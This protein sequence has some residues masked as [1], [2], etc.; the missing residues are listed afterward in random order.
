MTGALGNISIAQLQQIDGRL[1]VAG[2]DNDTNQGVVLGNGNGLAGGIGGD[3]LIVD[4]DVLRAAFYLDGGGVHGQNQLIDLLAFLGGKGVGDAVAGEGDG[5]G[6][7]G[8]AHGSTGG[9]GSVDLGNLGGL[10][11][12]GTGHDVGGG[13]DLHIVEGLA[14]NIHRVAVTVDGPGQ[15][16]AGACV[17]VVVVVA[18]GVVGAVLHNVNV[19]ELGTAGV[20]AEIIRADHTP[21]TGNQDAR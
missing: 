16:E 17:R 1:H 20:G 2:L 4:V 18:V 7:G 9:G 15:V 19:A 11:V 3:T 12:G 10:L 5:G 6:S 21:D 14:G 8:L 13:D